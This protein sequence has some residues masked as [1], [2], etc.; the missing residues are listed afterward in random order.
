MGTFINEYLGTIVV[1][2]GVL[3]IAAAIVIKMMR[4]KKRGKC[5]SCDGC[6]G[7]CSAKRG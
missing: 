3:A 4:D 1:L 6:S 7:N 5:S 2:A